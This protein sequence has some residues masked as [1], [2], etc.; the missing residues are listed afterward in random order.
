MRASKA[1]DTRSQSATQGYVR[2]SKATVTHS[3]SH[4]T[5][6]QWICW[7]AANS[8]HCETLRAHLEMRCRYNSMANSDTV[9]A[10]IRLWPDEMECVDEADGRLDLYTVSLWTLACGPTLQPSTYT[11]KLLDPDPHPET[12]FDLC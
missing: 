2:A 10:I 4:S 11:R 1:T 8:C 3:Q 5:R 9:G 12:G 6:E 7:E